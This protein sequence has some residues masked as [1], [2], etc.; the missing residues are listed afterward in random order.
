MKDIEYKKFAAKVFMWAILTSASLNLLSY[1]R[2]GT[3]GNVR[4]VA[5]II[6]LIMIPASMI[7]FGYFAARNGDRAE[8][9][10][11]GKLLTQ[12]SQNKE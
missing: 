9:F 5:N 8:Y 3:Q 10:I 4:V 6:T 11:Y 7:Y 2:D 12:N 1:L